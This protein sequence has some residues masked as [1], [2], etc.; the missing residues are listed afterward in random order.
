MGRRIPAIT[1]YSYGL[2]PCSSNGCGSMRSPCEARQPAM[3]SYST[4][5]SAAIRLG[6]F[7]T[8]RTRSGSALAI[9]MF[10][11]VLPQKDPLLASEPDAATFS[12]LM[13]LVTSHFN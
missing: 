2:P 5:D 11:R 8:S 6:S 13:E 7:L 1:A 3:R 12:A 10:H 4:L 9:L